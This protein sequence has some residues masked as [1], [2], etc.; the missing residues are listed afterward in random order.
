MLEICPNR[1]NTHQVT[2]NHRQQ[3]ASLIKNLH[4]AVLPVRDP[5]APAAVDTNAVD[6][7]EPAKLAARTAPGESVAAIGVEF[8]YCIVTITVGREV[9]ALIVHDHGTG[10]AEGRAQFSDAVE[11][12]IR[13]G[14]FEPIGGSRNTVLSLK[15]REIVKIIARIARL[16][17]VNS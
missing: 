2:S 13:L 16:S 3:P 9:F 12:G 11:P 7:G 14:T 17:F 5:H 15:H 1:A 10:A 6:E 8:V 4:A